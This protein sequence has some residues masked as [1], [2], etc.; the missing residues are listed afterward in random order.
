MKKLFINTCSV[1]FVILCL[2]VVGVQ[3]Q[4]SPDSIVRVAVGIQ[5]EQEV[6]NV[7]FGT[8][9]KEDV[10]GAV[11]TVNIAHL[12]EKNYQT[13]SLEGIRSFVGGYTDKIWGQSPLIL[14]DGVPRDASDVNATEVE[15]V[16]VLKSAS[17]VVLYGSKAARGVVLITTK[18]GKEHPLTIEARVNTGMYVPK[19]YPKYLDAASYMTL[20]NEA[21]DNDGVAHIYDDAAIYNTAAEVNPY[22][23]SD[24]DYFSSEYLRK[25][26][27]KTDATVEI[28]GGDKKTRYY[29]NFGMSYNNDLVNYGEQSKNKDLNFRVRGNVDMQ[30]TKWLSAKTDASVNFNNNYIGRGDFWG[31]SAT[32]RPNWFTSLIPVSMLDSNN[33]DLQTVIVN[34]NNVIDGKYLLGGNNAVQTNAFADMLAAGYI[35]YK[36]RTF[37]FNVSETAD[38]NSITEGLSFSNSFSIDYDNYYSEAYKQSYAT[39]EPTWSN[40]NGE[41]IIIDLKDYGEDGS[42]TNEYIG[43]SKYKQTITFFSQL[44]YARTFK[45]LH[46]VT[47]NLIAWGYQYR[48]SVDDGHDG[49]DYHSTSN[50]NLGM[51]VA[52]N[53]AHKY[54]VDF[55]G[56]IVH[57]SKLPKD[58]RKAFSPTVTLAWRISDENFMKD[59]SFI[60]NLM[61]TASYAKL[62]Q[63][64]DIADDEDEYYLYKG[65]YN[66]SGWFQWR[67]NTMGGGMSVL[68]QRGSNSSLDYVTRE[69]FRFGLKGALLKN[70]VTFEVNYFNQVTDGLLTQ[71]S[72]TIYP[73][74][75]N[76][77][78]YSYLPYINYNQDKRTGFDFSVSHKNKIGDFEYE[79]GFVGMVYNSEAAVRDEVYQD[80]YQYRA[81]KPLD[82]S[83]GYI[84]EG[85][86]AD[87]TD[88]D[89]HATQTFGD[90]LPGDFKYS[91]I[92]GDG[93]IDSRDQV[94][95]GKSGSGAS[96]FTYGI[97][98]T[99]KYKNWSLFAMG[100][101]QS[102]AIG[103]KNSDYY[104]VYGDRKY[105]EQ[106]LGRWTPETAS[107]ATYPR[108]TTK[109]NTN[110]FRNSTFWKYNNN[111]FDLTKAQLT[112]D[113]PEVIFSEKSLLSQLSVYVSGQ[114][115]LTIS[116][117]RKMMEM[118]I[119]KA[120]RCRF[121]NIGIKATF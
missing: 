91:D 33:V 13:N 47:A 98:L 87:Q 86:F 43:D 39:Y 92:N 65:Y 45:D 46:N 61:L 37:Q 96:P 14:V 53:Y 100:Q 93:I 95:L 89:S 72:S 34:S 106:V 59:A 42:A 66:D 113:F 36:E 6:V 12:L 35:R 18:R 82:A 5:M 107:T 68:S 64:I 104:W 118:N 52:Y 119:G 69:E 121:Y 9:D 88:I 103:Y 23:Y 58:N 110:N 8:Q 10:L 11:S 78:D 74:Y 44:N 56:A 48:N 22:K 57:S 49:S 79:L 15:S 116:K 101:G 55:S 26:Y 76:R 109:S 62:N 90:V 32:M 1:L 84:S 51:Q 67:D 102:G 16:T 25:A 41:D 75:F 29:T 108:L 105:S 81:D 80:D 2:G 63:D 7:A 70:K 20:Y 38:L 117:E 28:S 85:F 111:R 30:L 99:L 21:S 71:G 17:A 40:M 83:F 112:Y 19:S 115:L 3:A 50:A 4:E 77:W 94:K 54:Y 31:N 24:I 73:S 114:N 60:E 120:P 97:N 27:N